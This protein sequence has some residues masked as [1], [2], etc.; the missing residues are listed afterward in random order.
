M[1]LETVR[2]TLLRDEAHARLRAA[3]V[4][5][6]LPP[7]APLRDGDL[8][9]HLGLSR[10]PVR[11]ALRRLESEG[12]VRSRPQGWTRVAP[13]DDDEAAGA[14]Q[15]LAAVHA[16]AARTAAGRLDGQQLERLERSQRDFEDAVRDGDVDGALDADDRLHGVLVDASGNSALAATVDRWTPLVRRME[17]RRFA[18]PAASSSVLAHAELVGACRA[19][20]AE[21]AARL[22]E[23]LFRTLDAHLGVGPA[24]QEDQ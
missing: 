10:A 15:V 3:I 11:D 5:G 9:D 14:A 8:A 16:L 21:T 1:A 7:G 22:S 19:G 13:L 12:L 17:R 20:A 2:R 23:H 6:D 24:P 18:G 4:R